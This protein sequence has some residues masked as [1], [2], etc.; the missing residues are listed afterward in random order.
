MEKQH[1]TIATRLIVIISKL[2]QGE[3]FTV[4]ELVDEFNV[5]AR[6]IQRDLN[7]RLSFLPIKKTNGYYH[8]E[9]YYLGKLALKDIKNFATLSGIKGLY[10][11]LEDSFISDILDTKFNQAYLIKGHNYEDIANKSKEFKLLE[12]AILDTKIVQFTYKDKNRTV[13]PYKLIN[14]KGIWYLAGVEDDTLK[15]FSFNKISNLSI[16]NDTFVIDDNISKTIKDDDNVWFT[17]N[18]IEVTLEV[19]NSVANYFKRRKILPNQTIIE[20]TQDKLIVS[21]KVSYEDEILKIVRYW[22]PNVKILQPI[23]LQSNLENGLKEYLN[24]RGSD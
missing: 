6:T 18:Q 19:D 15:T 23:N 5:T 8:L 7:D 2:N 13:Q 16:L 12:T 1:D 4:D 24:G 20:D 17:P 3:R 9:E 11:T 10:P 21:T 14:T 22:I